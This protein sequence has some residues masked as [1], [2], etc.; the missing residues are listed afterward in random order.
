VATALLPDAARIEALILDMLRD[1]R[2]TP[3]DFPE[4]VKSKYGLIEVDDA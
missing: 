1:R 4:E 3:Y 2:G